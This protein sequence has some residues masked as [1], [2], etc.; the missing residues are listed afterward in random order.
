MAD[1]FETYVYRVGLLERRYD[2]STAV[3][4]FQNGVAIVFVLI[5]NFFARRFSDHALW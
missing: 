1:I 4:L 3:S 5:A 2:F